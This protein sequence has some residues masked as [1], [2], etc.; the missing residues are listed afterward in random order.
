MFD[1][2]ARESRLRVVRTTGAVADLYGELRPRSGR[3]PGLLFDRDDRTVRAAMMLRLGLRHIV[4][5]RVLGALARA[6]ATWAGRS[7]P[8][9]IA[10]SA[11]TPAD[12]AIF[13]GHRIRSF[14]ERGEIA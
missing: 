7:Q 2:L 9:R 13:R 10:N 12:P 11:I 14:P 3:R 6:V 4:K 1:D 5:A 8:K